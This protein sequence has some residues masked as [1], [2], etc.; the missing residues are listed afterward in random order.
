MNLTQGLP[1]TNCTQESFSFPP[2]KRRVVEARF[3]GGDI[4]SNGGVLLLKQADRLLGL[5]EAV[6]SVIGDPRRSAR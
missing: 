4:T 6:A 3:D 5:S 1:V 2:F